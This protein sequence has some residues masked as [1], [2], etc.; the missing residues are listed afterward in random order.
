MAVRYMT[1]AEKE[2]IISEA[3]DKTIHT[4]AVHPW[5]YSTGYYN[6]DIPSPFTPT[7]APVEKHKCNCSRQD[8][9]R[10]GCKCGGI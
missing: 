6:F 2:K 8:L 5:A 4:D 3:L 10:E 7:S 1:D 9:M